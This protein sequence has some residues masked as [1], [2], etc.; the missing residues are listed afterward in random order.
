MSNKIAHAP[1]TVL[2][3]LGDIAKDATFILDGVADEHGADC[4]VS[5]R[6]LKYTMAD[7]LAAFGKKTAPAMARGAV[8]LVVSY[9]NGSQSLA[10]LAKDA[11]CPRWLGQA[12]AATFEA[13][14]PFR[15]T[16]A[17]V[18]LHVG[19]L[20]D[21]IAAVGAKPTA[22]KA[23]A[24]DD[25]ADTDGTVNPTNPDIP[26][27]GSDAALAASAQYARRER[28]R[29]D[30]ARRLRALRA[31]VSAQAGEIAA[32]RAALAAAQSA[33]APKKRAAK[34]EAIAA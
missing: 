23:D 27:H 32:L 17:D 26:V 18:A 2:A 29:A 10:G 6:M 1:K 3:I 28:Q 30:T 13:I 11:A 22:E 25:A 16:V 4:F 33:A 34:R 8:F 14:R 31:T 15:P 19:A 21:R 20:L 24:A 7:A 5:A 12:M 9:L